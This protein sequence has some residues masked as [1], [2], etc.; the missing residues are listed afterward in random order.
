[1]KSISYRPFF[2]L[3]CIVILFLL[4]DFTG[5]SVSTIFA[6]SSGPPDGRTGSPVDGKTCNDD[7]HTSYP[8]NAGTAVFSISGPAIYTSG[9]TLNMT[10]SFGSSNTAKH[11]F[12]LSA[13]DANNNHVGTFSNVDSNTQTINGNYIKHTSAG[14]SQSG[15]AIWNVQ[16]TAPTS[17]V[18]NPVTFYVAGNEANGDSTNQGD[19]IYTT[20]TQINSVVSTPSPSPSPIPTTSPSD[21]CSIYAFVK[22]EDELPLKNVSV[23]L[24]GPNDYSECTKT[25][26]DG[27]YIFEELTSGDY[28]LVAS[29]SGYQTHTENL[30]LEPGEELEIE[31]IY[32]EETCCGSIYG[33][34]VNING[35]PVENARLKLRGL[36]KVKH[37][38]DR[39]VSDKDGFFEFSKCLDAGKYVITI[40]KKRYRP[41]QKTVPIEEGEEKDI[42]EIVLKRKSKKMKMLFEE[43]AE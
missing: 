29:K 31:T 28:T 8:L 1:M 15:N 21:E 26:E 23:C 11:G 41:A 2:V 14:S 20:I 13:L 30:H 33:Y 35:D 22:D 36:R 39:A 4:T 19:Y 17:E 37:L 34:V 3:W 10:V 25:D 42:G 7:C 9:E 12:E 6:Y 27:F 5:I 32:L 18:Q 40:N 24:A 16:W 38:K 43:E